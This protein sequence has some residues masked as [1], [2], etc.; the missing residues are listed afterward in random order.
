MQ[1]PCLPATP[2]QTITSSK[3]A[4]ATSSKRSNGQVMAHEAGTRRVKVSPN[5]ASM[6]SVASSAPLMVGALYA[7]NMACRGRGEAG[8]LPGH[9]TRWK[10]APSLRRRVGSHMNSYGEARPQRQGKRRKQ[11]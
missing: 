4:V 6:R 8:C 3:Q 2:W 10:H 5:E 1:G 9:V 7:S 11:G